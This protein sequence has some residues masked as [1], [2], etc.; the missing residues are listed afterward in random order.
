MPYTD[1]EK[2]LLARLIKQYGAKKGVSVYHGMLNSRKHEKN[3]G[4]ES[5]KKR[6]E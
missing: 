2:K 5:K 4:S 6:G 1:D 3:F